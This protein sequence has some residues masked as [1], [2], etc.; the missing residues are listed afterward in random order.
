[1]N[2]SSGERA[3][4][5]KERIGRTMEGLCYLGTVAELTATL[6][7][8]VK[9]I[10]EAAA[11]LEETLRRQE[12]AGGVDDPYNWTV[13]RCFEGPLLRNVDYE[14][15][16]ENWEPHLLTG[17]PLCYWLMIPADSILHIAA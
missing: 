12:T 7:R 11:R 16:V 13:F 10:R 2:M 14:I 1:M 3:M 5:K 17:A 4:I 6:P 15:G 8:L 9:E